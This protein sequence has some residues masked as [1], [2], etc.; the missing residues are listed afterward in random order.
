H[1]G[2]G[3][4]QPTTSILLTA[5]ERTA[6]ADWWN[7]PAP[8]YQ[9]TVRNNIDA[10][11]NGSVS[12]TAP[13]SFGEAQTL[14]TTLQAKAL[15]WLLTANGNTSSADFTSVEN[16]LANTAGLSGGS[17]ITGPFVG[18]NYFTAFDFINSGLTT[19]Q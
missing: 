13:T 8:G 7:N 5:A 17:S 3:I 2:T 12:G 16:A 14:S 9:T 10:V 1:P 19:S 15:R 4:T 11:A 6:L 18:T